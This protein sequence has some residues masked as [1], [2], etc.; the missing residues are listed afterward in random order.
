MVAGSR[1]VGE[2]FGGAYVAKFPTDRARLDEYRHMLG[3]AEE[4]EPG[5]IKT[6]A[7]MALDAQETDAEGRRV[8]RAMLALVKADVDRLGA[9]FSSGMGDRYSLARVAA[10][11]RLVDGFFTGF[12][13][14]L[15]ERSFPDLYTVY[16][17]GDDVLVIGPWYQAMRFALEMRRSFDE[18]SGHNPNLT[19]SAGIALFDPK[20]PVS[21]AAAEAEERLE[22]A[23]DDGR[24]RVH[25]IMPVGSSAIGWGAFAAAFDEADGLS[26]AIRAGASSTAL[27]YR[28]LSMDDRRGR[29]ERG[30]VA[31]ADWRA[32]LGYTLWRSL[33]KGAE[34]QRDPLLKLFGLDTDLNPGRAGSPA[35]ARLPLTIDLYRNR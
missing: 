10:L 12:L 32:K 16:A 11:S 18:F 14:A 28:L 21:R 35:P 30:D 4:V 19:L 27:L 8:G 23:K 7:A 34:A 24:D 9:V 1:P 31:C 5:Q 25:A 20:T 13:P 17:G 6:F 2:R 22:K 29:A 15:I 26:A 33:P 3:E